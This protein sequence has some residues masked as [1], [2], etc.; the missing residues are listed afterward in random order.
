MLVESV[1]SSASDTFPLCVRN[2]SSTAILDD[3][4]DRRAWHRASSYIGRDEDGARELVEA[5]ARARA[6]R[7][8]IISVNAL[9]RAASMTPDPARRV[10]WLA[11]ATIANSPPWTT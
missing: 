2:C 4:P 1:S 10:D 8:P 5:A 7:A 6:R 11:V 3:H 9:E